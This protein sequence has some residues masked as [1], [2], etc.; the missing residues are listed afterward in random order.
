MVGCKQIN[1]MLLGIPFPFFSSL[2]S[3]VR[4]SSCVLLMSQFSASFT[5]DGRSSPTIF[6]S[7]DLLTFVMN[8][9]TQPQILISLSHDD[10]RFGSNLHYDGV[11]N[12]M[13]FDIMATWMTFSSW[14]SEGLSMSVFTKTSLSI[15][16]FSGPHHHKSLSAK[17]SIDIP[18]ESKSA[19]FSFAFTWLYFPGADNVWISLILFATNGLN[20]PLWFLT[21]HKTFIQSVQ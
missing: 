14:I 18:R 4:I 8:W 9:I 6:P 1:L 5:S 16:K 19:G 3:S 21:H 13:N 10:W 20:F 11:F 12:C 2:Y 17:S 7:T 15:L